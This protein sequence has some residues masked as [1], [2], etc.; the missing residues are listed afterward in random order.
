[1][2]ILYRINRKLYKLL[3]PEL[4]CIL[5]LHRVVAQRSEGENR[6]L[7]ITPGFLEQT[8]KDYKQKGFLFVSIDEVS[9]ILEKGKVDK[10]FVCITFDDGYRDNY[11]DA[12]PILKKE[13]VP[14][15][16]YV[17]TGFIDNKQSMWWYP[18]ERLGLSRDELLNLDAEPLCTIGAHTITHPKLENLSVQEQRVEIK[19]S[20]QDL[21]RLLGHCVNHFS[22]PHGSYNE[23]TIAIIEESGFH[24]ALMAWGGVVRRGD[25]PMLLHRTILKQE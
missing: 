5:M 7:E 1:M 8:I 21:E 12:L 9:E 10:P 20:K 23:N 19:Q 4:G 3:H 18:N 15:T 25:N 13:Q 24:T 14:F 6:E 16:V 2:N 11:I 17:T 22:Y